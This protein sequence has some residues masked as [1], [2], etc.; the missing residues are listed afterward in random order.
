MND[1]PYL[2]WKTVLLRPYVF[3]FLTVYIVSASLTIGMTRAFFYL[4]TGYGVAW[5]SE[6]FSTHY[7]FPYGYYRYIPSTIDQ[8]LWVGGV[9]FMDSLSYVFLSYAS[10]GMAKFLWDRRGEA[11]L[12][13][14]S[15]WRF[16]VLG[17]ALVT[18]L[19]IIIDPVALRGDKW[20]L[21]KIYEYPEGGFYFGV[22][23]SN[24]IG[25]F[26]VGS[27]LIRI[28]QH[29]TGGFSP[30]HSRLK[31]GLT[32]A[33]VLYAGVV[34]FNLAMTIYIKAWEI[35]AADILILTAATAILRR[36]FSYSSHIAISDRS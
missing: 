34:I 22:P 23:L 31:Y 29:V 26:V 2:L 20:F 10:Y 24:F 7:G 6:W 21:G 15:S 18:L 35:L 32:L 8:E 30:S 16:T 12:D 25:W 1:I 33:V 14:L 9:P 3:A 27:V 17:A 13:R 5:C 4:P 19:D 11:A 36:L 28:L